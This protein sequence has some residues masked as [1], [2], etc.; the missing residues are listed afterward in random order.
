LRPPFGL[1]IAPVTY[2]GVVRV[3]G[4]LVPR[5]WCQNDVQQV[6]TKQAKKTQSHAKT[7][8][9]LSLVSCFFCCFFWAPLAVP[10][11]QSPVRRK[12]GDGAWAWDAHIYIHIYTHTAKMP[13]ATL[14]LL[15]AQS[16]KPLAT[17][18]GFCFHQR[19]IYLS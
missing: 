6:F 11:P 13:V 14:L 3:V 19:G 1:T 4:V 5:R 2:V 8:D 18:C 7:T 15:R 10:S 9:R 16:N 12:I 17:G